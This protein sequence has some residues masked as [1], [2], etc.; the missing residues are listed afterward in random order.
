[1]KICFDEEWAGSKQRD[2]VR[3]DNVV[4]GKGTEAGIGVQ[5]LLRQLESHQS[6]FTV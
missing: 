2:H 6:T 1:M 4:F 5:T 3:L